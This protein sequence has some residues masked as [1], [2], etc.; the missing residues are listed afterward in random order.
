VPLA[1]PFSGRVIPPS[2][3]IQALGH[4]IEKLQELIR[5]PLKPAPAWIHRWQLKAEHVLHLAHQAKDEQ[6]L[7]LL[8]NLDGE[9]KRPCP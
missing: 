2:P 6:N 7:V 8:R 4:H 3:P 1:G 9:A 5:T